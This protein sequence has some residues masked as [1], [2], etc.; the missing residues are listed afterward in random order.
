MGATG[1][2]EKQ[3]EVDDGSRSI[4]LII[5]IKWFHVCRK[6]KK[7]GG[8]G[9]TLPPAFYHCAFL[10]LETALAILAAIPPQIMTIPTI[11]MMMALPLILANLLI[12]FSL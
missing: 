4:R 8:N 5:V 7:A 9:V 3:E 12:A 6:K 10:D 11:I 1:P 2:D